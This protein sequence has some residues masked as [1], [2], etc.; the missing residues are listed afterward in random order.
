M[1]DIAMPLFGLLMMVWFVIAAL[2]LFVGSVLLV[3]VLVGGFYDLF[4]H[5]HDWRNE[6]RR[7]RGLCACCGY[8]LRCSR[9]RCPECG[10]P[11]RPLPTPHFVRI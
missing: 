7:K 2:G 8:D 5:R 6:G 1:G 3:S 11:V 9:I 4:R 10:Q